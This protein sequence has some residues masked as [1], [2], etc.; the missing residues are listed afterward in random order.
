MNNSTEEIVVEY[1]HEDYAHLIGD[2]F[3]PEQD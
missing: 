1:N 2:G 3:F